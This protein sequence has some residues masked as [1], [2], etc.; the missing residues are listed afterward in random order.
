MFYSKRGRKTGL[1]IG[2]WVESLFCQ[3]LFLDINPTM[4]WTVCHGRAVALSYG[5][6]DAP[7]KLFSVVDEDEIVD[8][9]VQHSNNDKVREST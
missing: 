9:V 4:D 7:S 6:F 3:N 2:S 5:L 8:V 1:K